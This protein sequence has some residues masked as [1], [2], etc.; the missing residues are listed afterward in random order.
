M[1]DIYEQSNPH[2]YH[3]PTE[4]NHF[5]HLNTPERVLERVKELLEKHPV[6]KAAEE[7]AVND[8]PPKPKNDGWT[9]K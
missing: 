9:G 3:R 8:A 5:L 1:L 6:T 7:L 4:G 2:F